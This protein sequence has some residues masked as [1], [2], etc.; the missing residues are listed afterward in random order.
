[1]SD[2]IIVGES[3]QAI[4]IDSVARTVSEVT[5]TKNNELK[6]ARRH[7]ECDTFDDVHYRDG[8]RLVVDDEGL[9]K[10]RAMFQ[11]EGYPQPLPNKAF[12]VRLQRESWATPHQS[13]ADIEKLITWCPPEHVP[14]IVHKLLNPWSNPLV[15]IKGASF[16]YC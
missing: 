15:L 1:M 5:I 8:L 16:D 14:L 13:V 12:I 3:I 10:T 11:I 6:D 7:L 9:Y 2:D 4:L